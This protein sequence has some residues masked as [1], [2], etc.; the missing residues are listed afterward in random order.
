MGSWF[1]YNHIP[2]H[3]ACLTD[4]GDRQ[5]HCTQDLQHFIVIFNDFHPFSPFN[6]AWCHGFRNLWKP[7][8]L[9][10]LVVRPVRTWKRSI[11]EAVGE[12]PT[13]KAAKSLEI[14]PHVK[15]LPASRWQQTLW[16]LNSTRLQLLFEWFCQKLQWT[17]KD[18]HN[19]EVWNHCMHML[20]LCP[21]R[22]NSRYIESNLTNIS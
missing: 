15:L 17:W 19:A 22:S 12:S 21:A 9:A 6:N 4:V 10:S 3:A 20:S 5:F 8:F 14:Q 16:D 18:A 13:R 1:N 7:Y 11:V 2:A